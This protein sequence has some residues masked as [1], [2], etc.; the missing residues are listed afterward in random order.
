MLETR[1]SNTGTR[2]TD[3][4][5]T[6]CIARAATP[7]ISGG[8][9]S[10][11][12]LQ[13]CSSVLRLPRETIQAL[14]NLKLRMARHHAFYMARTRCWSGPR[15]WQTRFEGTVIILAHGHA[16]D[17]LWHLC[18]ARRMEG[19]APDAAPRA[20]LA[21]GFQPR[22]TQGR[23]A[24]TSAQLRLFVLINRHGLIP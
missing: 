11:G 20:S 10:F 16:D 15:Q 1:G 17:G 7:G 13:C 21:A 6:A 23:R 14:I 22:G 12:L 5:T 4:P 2:A 19:D 24:G 8:G 18:A 9:A 3:P